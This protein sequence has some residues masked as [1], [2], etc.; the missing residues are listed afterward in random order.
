MRETGKP[1]RSQKLDVW[2]F[3]LLSLALITALLALSNG[4]E[5]GWSS[6]YV[7]WNAGLAVVGFVM[8]IAVESAREHPLLDLELFRIRNYSLVMVLAVFRSVG[9]FGG[10]FLLPIFL[11]RLAGYT[12][13]DTGLWMMPGALTLVFTMPIAGRMADRYHPAVLATIGTF[14]TG[15][16]AVH[17]RLA[18]SDQSSAFVIIGPQ[19]VR[20]FGLALMMA[21]LQTAA[22]NSVPRAEVATASAFLAVSQR[23]GGAFG[24]AVLNTYVTDA[25]HSHAVTLGAALPPQS[26][27]FAH[28]TY[29]AAHADD[30]SRP[31][32][33]PA[34]GR[35]ADVRR[36]PG[37]PPAGDDPGLPGR[38]RLRRRGH[39]D[40][41]AAVPLRQADRGR[42]AQGRRRAARA[43]QGRAP[44][45]GGDDAAAPAPGAAAMPAASAEA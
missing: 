13:I 9:L 37:L 11:E 12:T 31:R 3:C 30:P 35:R 27:R 19:I 41:P 7:L 34:A 28:A 21:P 40:R 43:G 18:R 25:V 22:L 14:V 26:L 32:R 42:P 5:K 6:D 10:V 2:G 33:R 17:V 15:G 8:F 20:G 4:Q 36:G 38:L 44:G 1:K 45:G 29:H 24:I 39:R 16:V 23:V